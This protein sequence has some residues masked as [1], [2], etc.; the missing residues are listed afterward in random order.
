V[1]SFLCLLYPLV[2]LL[3]S[4]GGGVPCCGVTNMVPS[5]A[6][7]WYLRIGGHWLFKLHLEV[8]HS[9]TIR[10]AVEA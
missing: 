8:R 7:T 2:T 1:L 10:D 9:R 5:A 6:D 4:D 3:N